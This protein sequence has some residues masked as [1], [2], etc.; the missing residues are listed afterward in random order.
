MVIA[1]SHISKGETF[2]YQNFKIKKGALGNIKIGMT[3]SQAERRF[4]GLTKKTSEDWLFGF[5]GGSPAYLYYAGDKVVLGLI[6][7]L[8]TDTLMC[9]I[10]A[11][12]RLHTTNGL[13]PN[14]TV[15]ALKEKYPEMKLYL[16]E[17][18][19]WEIFMDKKNGWDFIFATDKKKRIGVYTNHEKPSKPIRI[20]A[21]TAWI[22]IR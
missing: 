10:V 22:T 11:D 3:I 4:S 8:D 5:D 21:K 19:N 6:P 14:S 15:K 16:N 18:N 7:K 1:Q 20:T 13:N 17:T 9:I 12:K 2:A